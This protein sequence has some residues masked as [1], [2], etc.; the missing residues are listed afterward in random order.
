LV[1]KRS[2]SENVGLHVDEE[3]M[4]PMKEYDSVKGCG[5]IRTDWRLPLLE[6]IRN[7]GM[8]SI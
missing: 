7:L 3:K 2:K 4:E 5:T 6:C 1:T 8:V